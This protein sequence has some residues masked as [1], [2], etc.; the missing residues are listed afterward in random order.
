MKTSLLSAAMIALISLAVTGCSQE[1]ILTENADAASSAKP[2]GGGKTIPVADFYGNEVVGLLG[3][4]LGTIVR[5]TGKVVD[6]DSTGWKSTLGKTLLEV[7]TVNG[8]K[9]E[10]SV[11]FP[12]GR[13]PEE[14]EKPKPET[15]FDYYVHEWGEFDGFVVVPKGLGI[16]KPMIANDGFYYRRQITIHKSLR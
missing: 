1:Y 3:H 15:K 14:V 10:K 2:A 5:V 4:P 12:F 7:E 13:A 6:G 8:K 16:E 11:T 9:L